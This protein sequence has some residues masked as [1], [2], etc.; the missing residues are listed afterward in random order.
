MRARRSEDEGAKC[1]AKVLARFKGSNG[2]P[3]APCVA[4]PVAVDG[5]SSHAGGEAD[6]E[7]SWTLGRGETATSKAPGC[8]I[9]PGPPDA[10]ES[11]SDMAW[12]CTAL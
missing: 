6:A 5:S 12:Q 8:V 3:E 7:P 9:G 11:E 4:D 1:C 2:R 10:F